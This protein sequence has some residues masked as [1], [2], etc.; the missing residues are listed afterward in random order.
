MSDGEATKLQNDNDDPAFEVF[1]SLPNSVLEK[2][3]L[4]GNSTR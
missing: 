2:M 4:Y 1:P 3:G